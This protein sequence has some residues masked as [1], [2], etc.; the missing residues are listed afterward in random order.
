MPSISFRRIE[1]TGFWF[2]DILRVLD[3]TVP[4]RLSHVPGSDGWPGNKYSRQS[5][6]VDVL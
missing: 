4:R 1:A 2:I 6:G 3:I 5:S